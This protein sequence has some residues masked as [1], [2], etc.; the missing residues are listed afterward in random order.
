MEQSTSQNDSRNLSEVILKG[1]HV[2]GTCPPYS[3]KNKH[4]IPNGLGS[5]ILI[6]GV[7]S[8]KYALFMDVRAQVG[9][10][11]RLQGPK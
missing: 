2:L 7:Q 11:R 8:P 3:A 4:E 10:I 6:S 5:N 1:S 9:V